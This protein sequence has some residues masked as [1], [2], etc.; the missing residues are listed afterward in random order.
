MVSIS[1]VISASRAPKRS[2]TKRAKS[3]EFAQEPLEQGRRDKNETQIG[4]GDPLGAIF[5]PA[6]QAERGLD[7]GLSRRHAV[8]QQTAAVFRRD[9]DTDP[10]F[11]Q[12]EKTLAGRARREKLPSP[13]RP[14]FG[15]PR[16]GFPRRAVEPGELR[17]IFKP[18]R[19][20]LL[21]QPPASSSLL[22]RA[23]IAEPQQLIS[24]RAA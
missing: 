3:G 11:E 13:P 4:L 5:Q 16:Q 19:R 2:K 22:K 8:E 6:H 18:G 7:A 14:P 9:A 21:V 23:R 10:P 20:L 17:K 24:E 15:Q 12:Q 1:R